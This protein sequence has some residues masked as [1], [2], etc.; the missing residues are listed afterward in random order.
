MNN[1]TW[2]SS[3]KAIIVT[4][5]AVAATLANASIA[6]ASIAKR[7][8]SLNSV[9]H[10]N[11]VRQKQEVRQELLKQD[12]VTLNLGEITVVLGDRSKTPEQ[13]LRAV[14]KALIHL[15]KVQ[16]IIPDR[17]TQKCEYT[18]FNEKF[19]AE[20]PSE[21]VAKKRAVEL[22]QEKFSEIVCTRDAVTCGKLQ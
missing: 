17:E 22:C 3:K 16:G 13:R 6:S 8:A 15:Y 2:A 4:V 19:S 18:V 10:S 7:T 5:I 21:T 20:G 1:Q 12:A 11:Q 9:K 14:E